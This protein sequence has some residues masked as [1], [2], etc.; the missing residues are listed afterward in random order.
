MWYNWKKQDCYSSFVTQPVLRRNHSLFQSELSIAFELVLLLSISTTL[1][2][3][4]CWSLRPR[5]S[6]SSIFT[7]TACIV[8]QYLSKM[9]PILLAFHGFVIRRKLVSSLNLYAIYCLHDQSSW[10]PP[11]VS[12]TTF[13][14][15][16]GISDLISKVSNFKH[17]TK[18]WSKCSILLLASLHLSQFAGEKNF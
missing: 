17:H 12:K 10:Y 6:V 2:S 1:S 4:N 11:F 8:R 9:W 18:L 3:S 13:Q 5:L 7:S 14:N 15:F 16:S